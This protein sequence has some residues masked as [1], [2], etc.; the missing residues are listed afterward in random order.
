VGYDVKQ[1]G[2]R[3]FLLEQQATRCTREDRDSSRASTQIVNDICLILGES[4]QHRVQGHYIRHVQ[5]LGQRENIGACVSAKYPKLVF[6]QHNVA[7]E[8][9]DLSRDFEI[10]ILDVT[11]DRKATRIGQRRH[12]HDRHFSLVQP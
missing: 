4:W 3:Q 10:A 6:N 8:C 11:N 7:P 12:G 5:G 1:P 2:G 9:V